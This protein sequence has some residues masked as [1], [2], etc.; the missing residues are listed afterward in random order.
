MICWNMLSYYKCS[1]LKSDSKTPKAHKR[2]ERC[3]YATI[4]KVTNNTVLGMTNCMTDDYVDL[5]GDIMY[6][7]CTFG[8]TITPGDDS[9]VG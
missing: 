8:A 6:P 2:V 3:T 4:E 7:K 9:K 1:E 5:V